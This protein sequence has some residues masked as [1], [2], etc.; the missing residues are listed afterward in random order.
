VNNYDV[1][2]VFTPTVPAKVTFVERESLNQQ[3]MDALKT[4]GKQVVV[5]GQSGSGKSTLLTN[6]IAQLYGESKIL[7]RCTVATNFESLLLGAFDQ[8]DVF[9]TSTASIK[10][11]SSITGKLEQAYLAV[12][13]NIE[14]TFASEQQSTQT[15]LLP[16]Q[17]TAQRLAEFCGAARCCWILEDF[18]K[19]PDS[20]KNK[21]SQ[22]M[23]VFTDMAADYPAAKTVAI[24]AVDTARQVIQYDPEMR[25]RV[26]EI[27]V[28]MMT[29]NEL[30]DILQKGEKLLNINFGSHKQQI[31]SIPLVWV[32]FVIKSH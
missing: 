5:Y 17:L 23:K 13:M 25:T 6:K 28:P 18:H 15:R 27:A 7:S 30:V 14:A 2:E 10:T 29:T 32:P 8:L 4:P 31:A 24:G 11:S 9:Y 1:R 20:E 19:V 12:K 26:A 22:I 16:P 21:L 3:L